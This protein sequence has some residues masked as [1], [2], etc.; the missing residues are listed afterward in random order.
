MK[1]LY[2]LIFLCLPLSSSFALELKRG[3]YLQS[4]SDVQVTFAWRT[5]VNSNGLVKYGTDPNDLN[6][7]KLSNS[8]VK[9]H[10]V[11][12][13]GLNPN[14]KYYYSIG[15]STEVLASGPDYFVWTAPAKGVAKKT[16]M[17]VLGDSGTATADARDVRDAYYAFTGNT[18]TDLWMMLGDN[19][20]PN[21]TD[22]QFQN[23]VFDT[24][25]EMLRKSVLW[26][27]IG[28]HS[29]LDAGETAYL[30]IF[31]LPT[32]AEAGG[33]A[34][35]TENYYS[36]DY[37]NIHLV[38][39]DS[40]VSSRS[41]TGAMAMWFEEDLAATDQ[42]WIIVYWHHPPYTK[43][44]HDSDSGNMKQMREVF[45]PILENAGVDLVLGGHS[46]GYERSFLLQ[47]HYGLSNTFNSNT[48]IVQPGNGREGED[49]AY[50]KPSLGVNPQQG[51]VYTVAG[52]S[53]KVNVNEPYDHPA[54]FISLPSLGSVVIDIDGGRLDMQF[55]NENAQVLDSFSMIKGSGQ[56]S[57]VLNQNM[58]EGTDNENM[59]ATSENND[60]LTHTDTS[61]G[62]GLGCNAGA[63]KNTSLPYILLIWSLASFIMRQ[64]RIR[65]HHLGKSTTV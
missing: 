42:D 8:N 39:L 58:P 32:N 24:Y 48:M 14:T 12:V 10:F 50:T 1:H 61:V 30:D 3:P 33:L 21:G 60:S 63:L 13:T 25:P 43:G 22:T 52:S 49:G 17:W 4:G 65:L 29:L 51:V 38:V 6:Q 20:Y 23:A 55:I 31:D 7:Q 54:M 53:G 47:G 37:G 19:A 59:D 44:S 45:N 2:L 36:F 26:P 41:A 27:A 40:L 57:E 64:R 34:S 11:T 28:N 16:R 15:S 56:A 35:G 46:H 9:D 62:N 18:H 5:D